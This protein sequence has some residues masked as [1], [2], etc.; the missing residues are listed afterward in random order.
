M[1]PVKGSPDYIDEQKRIKQEEMAARKIGSTLS[2]YSAWKKSDR[3][4]R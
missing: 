1:I 4:H 3:C 2:F